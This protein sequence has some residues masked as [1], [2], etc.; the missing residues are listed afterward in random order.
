MQMAM[1]YKG[2]KEGNEHAKEGPP[3]LSYVEGPTGSGKTRLMQELLRSRKS[4]TPDKLVNEILL[5]DGSLGAERAR[6]FVD[7]WQSEDSSIP[8]YL[9]FMGDGFCVDSE[10]CASGEALARCSEALRIL[11]GY[12]QQKPAE[13]R[14]ELGSLANKLEMATGKSIWTDPVCFGEGSEDSCFAESGEGLK[15]SDTSV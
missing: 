7:L 10:E 13:V 14:A 11:C 15:R 4:E 3:G 12:V 5:R 8:I 6:E 9:D 2:M 1:A